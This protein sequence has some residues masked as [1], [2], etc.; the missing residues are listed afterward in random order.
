MKKLLSAVL[1]LC[2][3]FGTA[4]SSRASD[5]PVGFGLVSANDVALRKDAGGQKITRL[6]E[7]TSVWITD[8][9]KDSRGN[10]QK[11]GN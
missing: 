9:K 7:G 5:G 4:F 11:S 6:P 3:V 8:S 10:A 1:L 2:L